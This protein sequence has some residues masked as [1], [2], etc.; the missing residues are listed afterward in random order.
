MEDQLL[1]GTGIEKINTDRGKRDRWEKEPVYRLTMF[2]RRWRGVR[3]SAVVRH[4]QKEG[5]I[6]E[7][8]RRSFPA[9]LC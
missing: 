9:K 5:Q 2:C 7:R 3:V 4:R 8:N 6:V 1:I